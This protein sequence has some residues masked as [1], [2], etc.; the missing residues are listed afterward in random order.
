MQTNDPAELVREHQEEIQRRRAV[1]N[2]E[3]IQ[4]TFDNASSVCS[5]PPKNPDQTYVVFSLSNEK[6][7][8][9]MRPGECP[10]VRIYGAFASRDE[11]RSYATDLSD[12]DPGISLLIDEVH[13]WIL[14]PRNESRLNDASLVDKKLKRHGARLEREREEFAERQARP[15]EA[16]AGGGRS[17]A[18]ETTDAG[19]TSQAREERRGGRHAVPALYQLADQRLAVVSFV[20]DDSSEFLFKVYGL[21]DSSSDANAWVRNVLSKQVKDHH[22]DVVATCQWCYPTTMKAERVDAEAFRN[23]ELDAIMNHH[24]RE[25]S[26]VKEFSEWYAAQEDTQSN[27]KSLTIREIEPTLD[28]DADG[29]DDGRNDGENDGAGDGKHNGKDG[30]SVGARGGEDADPS[31]DASAAV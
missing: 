16:P 1:A 4:D 3:Q 13:K 2:A 6:F 27:S 25:P 23:K 28:S 21:V 15:V 12:F 8:P 10:A 30:C 14:A 22:I 5:L 19:A 29:Q 17:D 31:N 20:C 9:R 24:K 11:A 26:R 7:A 18:A